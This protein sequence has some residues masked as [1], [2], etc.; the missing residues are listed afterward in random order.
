MNSRLKHKL[1][2]RAACL[3]LEQLGHRQNYLAS[4][5]QLK[6]GEFMVESQTKVDPNNKYL[7]TD[8]ILKMSDGL[9]LNI[10]VHAV[11]PHRTP[12]TS[13]W[14]ASGY[15]VEAAHALSSKTVYWQCVLTTEY[16]TGLA[17]TFP[18]A[19]RICMSR[20]KRN[21]VSVISPLSALHDGRLL[22]QI[23]LGG[24]FI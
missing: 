16:E 21:C 22:Q 17:R 5:K 24:G 20:G 4:L 1:G 18:A 7:P 11:A 10:K 9:Q 12:H 14:R 6:P 15:A 8:I 3:D 13:L 2:V 23:A 19:H